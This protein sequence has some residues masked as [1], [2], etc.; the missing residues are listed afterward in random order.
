M[1]VRHRAR[2]VFGVLGGA[3]GAAVWAGASSASA[4]AQG[5]ISTSAA[6]SESEVHSEYLIRLPLQTEMNAFANRLTVALESEPV[7]MVRL[8]PVRDDLVHLALTSETTARWLA[9]KLGSAA[10]SLSPNHFLAPG[11]HFELKR[12][13]APDGAAPPW[14][15]IL[16]GLAG[17]PSPG[18]LTLA[19][20]PWSTRST[21]ELP[22]WPEAPEPPE[23]SV[24][25]S[26]SGGSSE[27]HDGAE[28]VPRP[29]AAASRERQPDPLVAEDWAFQSVRPP[30]QEIGPFAPVTV[31][32]IDTGID[33]NHEDLMEALWRSPDDAAQV[34][35]DF[36]HGHAR[37][38]DVFYFDLEG[39]V[40]DA[41]CRMGM[42]QRAY[43]INPGHGTHCAGHIAAVGGNGIG[44]EGL[45]GSGVRL[46]TLKFVRDV[47]EPH[48]GS[49]DEVSAIRALDFAVERGA[50]VINLSWGRKSTREAAAGS[51]LLRALERAR[52]AGVLVVVAAGNHGENLDQVKR[53]SFPA[54]YELDNLIVVA[55]TDPEDRLTRFSNFGAESVDLAAPGQ[56]VYSTMVGDRYGSVIASAVD[57]HGTR[58]EMTWE[59]TS[60]AAPL[61]AGAAARVWSRYPELP[62]WEI[63]RKIL[64]NVR[65]VESLAGKVASGG[66]LDVSAALG[67]DRPPED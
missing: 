22:P 8:S 26:P 60:M 35:Y 53:P 2:I 31:A 39:C 29:G 23:V 32:L 33:Y 50:K 63:R 65:P 55:A 59:G 4:A 34:G 24:P 47:G 64:D 14:A 38:Y 46:M 9:S 19:P 18:P 61:V 62:Y 51:E 49:G 45:G 36:A 40:Q 3:L 67:Q 42:D 1:L 30:E 7:R 20:S 43:L 27:G 44:M 17:P 6:A 37:P 25:E 41:R 28:S 15:G 10:E 13:R 66:V 11:V 56:R 48:A 58:V 54:A 57:P 5:L 16:G 12:S 52:E 21:S